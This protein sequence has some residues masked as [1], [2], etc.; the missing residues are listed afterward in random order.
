MVGPKKQDFWPKNDIVKENRCILRIQGAQV[1][2]QLCMILESK[3]VQK[4]NKIRKK[5]FYK[6][7]PKLTFLNDFFFFVLKQFSLS[8]TI[9]GQKSCILRPT[10]FEILQPN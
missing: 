8:M 4:F 10:I 6:K 7:C 9:L 2:Q 5:C 1:G 3:V